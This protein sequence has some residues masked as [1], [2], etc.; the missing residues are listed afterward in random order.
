MYSVAELMCWTAE[1]FWGQDRVELLDDAHVERSRTSLQALKCTANTISIKSATGRRGISPGNQRPDPPMPL[2]DIAFLAA[3]FVLLL[4]GGE[5]LKWPW[6]GSRSREASGISPMVIG[7]TLVGFG[8]L[9]AGTDGE[10]QCPAQG[11]GAGDCG[12]Q[13]P[14][15]ANI[16]NIFPGFWYILPR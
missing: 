3:G 11:G 9:R 8:H 12:R 5:Y 16:A 10:H 2:T 6:C 13:C 1:V 14:W 15:A 7:L 4:V